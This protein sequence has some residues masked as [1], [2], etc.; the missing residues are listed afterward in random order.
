MLK[1][2]CDKEQQMS[3]EL[4]NM[5]FCATICF[6]ILDKNIDD[7]QKHLDYQLK[8]DNWTLAS[9][10]YLIY[11]KNNYIFSDSNA[12]DE[13]AKEFTQDIQEIFTISAKN[14]ATS[15]SAT[16]PFV[17]FAQL[18]NFGHIKFVVKFNKKSKAFTV[19]SEI[20]NDY[21][22]QVNQDYCDTLFS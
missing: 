22:R 1:A 18:G 12:L 15:C 9:E 3:D 14:L 4:S 7:L 19:S 2:D 8:S 11:I 17:G 6:D 20:F 5:G 10:K 21:N 16:K 13:I